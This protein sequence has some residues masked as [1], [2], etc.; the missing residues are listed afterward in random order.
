[1]KT[2]SGGGGGGGGVGGWASRTNP[3]AV[4]V[5]C[6]HWVTA[7][8]QAHHKYALLKRACGYYCPGRSGS[9]KGP[10]DGDSG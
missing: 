8:P 6:H 7:Q 2:Q 5:R 1:M 9:E 10:W 4:H 3:E